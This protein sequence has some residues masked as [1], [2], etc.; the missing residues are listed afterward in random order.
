MRVLLAAAVALATGCFGTSARDGGDDSGVPPPELGYCDLDADCVGAG[1]SC[2]GCPEYAVSALSEWAMAC[3]EIDCPP[4]DG[5]CSSLAPRCA[6]HTCVLACPL[7][8]CD[9]SCAE[10]F[11]L[12]ASGCLTC[13]CAQGP[14][15]PTCTVDGECARVPADCCGCAMGGADTA[16]PAAEVAAYLAG[17]HCDADPVCPGVDV[18]EIGAVVQCVLGQC[19]LAPVTATPP[20]GACGAPDLPPCP[21][22]QTCVLNSDDGATQAGVGVC[23]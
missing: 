22:G 1:A 17:L 11:A 16:I 5:T 2:C 8:A 4:P 20:A 10:G 14:L 7:V 9:L 13:A 21:S 12:D 3:G 6:D 23:R 19:V 15:L 18:C